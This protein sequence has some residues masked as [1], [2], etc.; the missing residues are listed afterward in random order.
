MR[1]KDRARSTSKAKEEET[2]LKGLG[3]QVRLLRQNRNLTQAELAEKAEAGMKYLGEI[4]RG[5][6]NPGL[7]LLWQ[8]S[9]ALGVEV[10]ELF[11]FSVTDGEQESRM[12]VQI[13][14]LLKGRQ[15][16]GLEQAARVLRVL[17]E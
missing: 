5:Q 17:G 16:K 6:T 11:L 10:F 14:G 15:G 8:L 12:R 1:A 9:A 3:R 7:R 4:E 13:M 2:F